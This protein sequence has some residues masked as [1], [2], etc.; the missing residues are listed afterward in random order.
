M[1]I[2][3]DVMKA[4]FDKEVVET[5]KIQLK[6]KYTD[7]KI[8]DFAKKFINGEYEGLPNEIQHVGIAVSY[9]MGWNK[10]SAGRIYDSLS[11]HAFIIGCKTGNRI[12]G[13]QK[14]V[15]TMSIH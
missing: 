15:F 2:A 6:G 5:I 13:E 12:W 9:D 7:S 3:T 10:R 11:G 1:E 8:D 4:A 14:K